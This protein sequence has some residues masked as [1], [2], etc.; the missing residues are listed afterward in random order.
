M[1][2]LDK[3]QEE[4]AFFAQIGRA[5]M[6]WNHVEA[7]TRLLLEYT[8]GPTNYPHRIQILVCDLQNV[9]LREAIEAIAY[10]CEAELAEHLRCYA[11]IFDRIRIHRNRI[12]HTHCFVGYPEGS[13][14]V[15]IGQPVSA[16]GGTL[17]AAFGQ[18]TMDEIKQ[19]ISHQDAFLEYNYALIS[20]ILGLPQ[21]IPLSSI[22]KPPLPDKYDLPRHNMI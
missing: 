8:I 17:R 7:N 16:K 3:E 14:V 20:V 21:A 19:L 15:G 13:Q 2:N 9:A 1:Q 10:D 4:T 11:K 18:I 6:K 5:V 12:T 22:K